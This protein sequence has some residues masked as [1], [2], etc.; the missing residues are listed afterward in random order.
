MPVY[1]KEL[2]V[3]AEWIWQHKDQ[4]RYWEWQDLTS[5]NP[6]QD[7]LNMPDIMAWNIFT[8]LQE[9]RLML[10]HEENKD[11]KIIQAYNKL[12]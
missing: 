3:A 5:H 10:P 7:T 4:P 12:F 8:I 9:R 2:A 11:G 1:S 6:A